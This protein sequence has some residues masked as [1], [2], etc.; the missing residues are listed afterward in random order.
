MDFIFL[1]SLGLP[2]LPLT[3][4]LVRYR[5]SYYPRPTAHAAT[6]QP[7]VESDLTTGMP[8]PAG[9]SSGQQPVVM[10]PPAPGFLEIFKR[11][12]RTE[13]SR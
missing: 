1:I 6:P 10:V 13:V 4:T 3:G 9:T 5:A 12:K 7:E 8:E 2:L 11:V